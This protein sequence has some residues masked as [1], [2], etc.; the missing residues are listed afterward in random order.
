[1]TKIVTMT[2]SLIWLFTCNYYNRKLGFK[3][4]RYQ[5]LI[6]G[7]MP[8]VFL[9]IMFYGG[10]VTNDNQALII[11]L[12]GLIVV[13]FASFYSFIKIKKFYYPINGSLKAGNWI[14]FPGIVFLFYMV[15]LIIMI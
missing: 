4:R 3:S 12:L 10:F 1:M 6:I 11:S 5:P 7:T 13:M 2:L 8:Y 14:I 15:L 9:S